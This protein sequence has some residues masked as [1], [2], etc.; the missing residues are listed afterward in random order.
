MVGI[1]H[2]QEERASQDQVATMRRLIR[3]NTKE[4]LVHASA[5]GLGLIFSGTYDQGLTEELFSLIDV[6]EE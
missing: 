1:P 4:M 6:G 2:G 3:E 5:L